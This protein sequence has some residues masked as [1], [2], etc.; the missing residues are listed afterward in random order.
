[1]GLSEFA[2]YDTDGTYV[3]DREGVDDVNFPY[4]LTFEP[5][6]GVAAFLEEMM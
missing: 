1:M 3:T 2:S 4:E 5:D 6:A